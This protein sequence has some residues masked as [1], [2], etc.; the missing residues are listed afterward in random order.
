MF[1]ERRVRVLEEQI[2]ELRTHNEKL[3]GDLT[4]ALETLREID[5][6]LE[7]TKG[8][9]DEAEAQV[10]CKMTISIYFT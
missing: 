8:R 4:E 3:K 7:S 2:A 9:A 5:D 1:A 10:R 6:E